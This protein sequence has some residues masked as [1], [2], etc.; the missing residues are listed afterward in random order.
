MMEGCRLVESELVSCFLYGDR[1]ARTQYAFR[2]SNEVFI[3]PFRRRAPGGIMDDSGK[4]LRR[5]VE[6]LGV[7]RHAVIVAVVGRQQL[8]N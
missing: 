6:L 2:L 8:V 4:V 7:E 5:K 1:I 3:D